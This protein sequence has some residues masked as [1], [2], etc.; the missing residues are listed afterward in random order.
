MLDMG[1]RDDLDFITDRLPPAPDRQT[2]LFSA[3][4]SPAIQQIARTTLHKNH[5]FIDCVDKGDSPVHAHIPQYF[6][7]LPSSADQIPHILK[8]IAHD[9]LENPGRSKIM[10]FL[11]TTKLTQLF[12]TLL[13]ELAPVTTPAA[14]HTKVY[15]IHSKRTQESRT[16]TSD[17]FR[18]DTRGATV[19]VTSDVSARG[20]DYP[21]VTRVIQVGIPASYEQYIHRVGRTGRGSAKTQ[22]RSDFVLLPFEQG[23]VTWQLT[24]IPMRP[25]TITELDAQVEQLAAAY[26]A[27]PTP[28]PEPPTPPPRS[29][30]MGKKMNLASRIKPRDHPENITARLLGLPVALS[31]L[32]AKVDPTAVGETFASML[33]YYMPKTGELRIQK[34]VMI[35]GCKEWTVD[36]CKLPRPPYISPQFLAKLGFHDGRTKRFGNMVQEDWRV[37]MDKGRRKDY[38]YNMPASDPWAENAEEYRSTTYSPKGM[39]PRFTNKVNKSSSSMRSRR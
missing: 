29:A 7:V 22:G 16:H 23:F 13:R 34:E 31:N 35:E 1:F 14:E 5:A 17:N 26:D 11:P 28:L 3:T 38:G 33:G 18:A 37:K 21:G 25:L 24:D 15:E 9:Q 39:T 12:A 4:V 19:L 27:K 20:V 10:L 8:L 36:A 32:L 30:L 6:T 2:F